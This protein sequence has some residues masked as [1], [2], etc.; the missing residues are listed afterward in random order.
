MALT[1]E[2]GFQGGLMD[3]AFAY[4]LNATHGDELIGGRV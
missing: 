3:N 1:F 2:N 4:M